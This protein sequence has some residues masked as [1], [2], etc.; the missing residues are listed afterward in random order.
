M[1]S[2]T[3]IDGIGVKVAVVSGVPLFTYIDPNVS[4][5]TTAIRVSVDK[6]ETATLPALKPFQLHLS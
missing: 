2:P 4:I 3:V 5:P 1:L 6:L